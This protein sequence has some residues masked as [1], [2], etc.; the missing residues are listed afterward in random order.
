MR[1]TTTSSTSKIQYE[2]TFKYYFNNIISMKS[3]RSVSLE[4]DIWINI[5][6]YMQENGIR[7]ISSAIEDLIKKS[8]EIIK[9]KEE[10]Y[11]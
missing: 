10:K 5:E 2:V 7:D 6:K 3:S 1:N 4:T 8:L 9:T 11:E